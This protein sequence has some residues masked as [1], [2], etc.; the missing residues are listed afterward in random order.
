MQE[1]FAFFSL[2]HYFKGHL[3]HFSPRRRNYFYSVLFQLSHGHRSVIFLLS[4]GFSHS[5]RGHRDAV[6]R[7]CCL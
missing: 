5:S 2:F 3:P 6:E 4:L 1:F 7:R